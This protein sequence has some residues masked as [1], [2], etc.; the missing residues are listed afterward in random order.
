MNKI[1]FSYATEDKNKI[2]P[3]LDAFRDYDIPVWIDNEQIML[4]SSI[5]EKISNGIE[6]CSG[7]VLFLSNHYLDK[8]WTTEERNALIERKILQSDFSL[9]VVKLESC[10]VP[11]II[12]HRLWF[13]DQNPAKLALSFSRLLGI[14]KTTEIGIDVSDF[15]SIITEQEMERLA[16][17]I[18]E[19]LGQKNY[20]FSFKPKKSKSL[21]IKLLTPVVSNLSD[22]LRF[23]KQ[24]LKTNE[25][26]RRELKEQL[27]TVAIGTV[28]APAFKL[29][30]EK[31]LKDIENTRNEL[32][33]VIDALIDEIN[34]ED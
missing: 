20:K 27:L 16:L 18:D 25:F 30:L 2:A 7:A 17:V 34:E 23:Q 4:G 8:P 9:V 31:K 1:F 5:V 6:S 32:R 22:E 14:T 19:N 24:M 29:Q 21:T 33:E 28:F 13:E 11:P 15:L 10:N 3:Y 26:F 12:Q